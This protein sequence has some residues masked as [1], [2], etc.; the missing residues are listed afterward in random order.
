MAISAVVQT[1]YGEDR[2]LYIRINNIST[3]NHGVSSYALFRGFISREAF[4]AGS[5]YLWEK[6]LELV[7]DV[8]QPIW[9][10]TYLEIKKLPE[11]ADSIDC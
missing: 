6:E 5:S 4:L 7:L 9:T 8:S 11:F 3:S 2:D 10:Q 1:P